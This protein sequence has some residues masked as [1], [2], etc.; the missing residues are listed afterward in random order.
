[1]AMNH[2][3]SIGDPKPHVF[4]APRWP[5]PLPDPDQLRAFEHTGLDEAVICES[6]QGLK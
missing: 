5:D 4:Y 6:A 3:T 1:M 2:R